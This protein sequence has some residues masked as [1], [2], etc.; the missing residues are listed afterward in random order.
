MALRVVL[1]SLQPKSTLQSWTYKILEGKKLPPIDHLLT[2]Q[3]LTYDLES[4]SLGGKK[5]H[6]V[7]AVVAK[8]VN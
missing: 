2:P 3:A 8:V 6:M 1:Y 4:Q 5:D 7:V